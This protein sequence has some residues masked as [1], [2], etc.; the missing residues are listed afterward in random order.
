MVCHIT[1]ICLHSLNKLH[2]TELTLTRH[3]NNPVLVLKIGAV[4]LENYQELKSGTKQPIPSPNTKDTIEALRA[5]AMAGW[6]DYGRY[7]KLER[8]EEA[9]MNLKSASDIAPKDDSALPGISNNLGGCL[10]WRFERLGNVEDINESIERYELATSLTPEGDPRRA[11]NLSNMGN[12]FQCRFDWLGNLTDLNNAIKSKQ[13]AVDLTPDGH[14]EKPMYLNN[15][16]VSLAIRF[17]QLGELS[18]L[19]KAVA[20]NQAAVDLTPDNHPQKFRRLINLGNCFDTRFGRFGNLID[21]DSAITAKQAALRLVPDGHPEK[22]AFLNNLGNSL[23]D[24]FHR[25]G[26]LADLNN[27]IKFKQAAADVTPEDNPDKPRFLC[28]LGSSLETRFKQLGNIVDLNNAVTSNQVAVDLTPDNHPQKPH[29]LNSLGTSLETRFQR[30]GKLEDIHNAITTNQMA[31]DL[32]PDNHLHKPGRL[33]NLGISLLTRFKTLGNSADIDLSI[34]SY[35]TAIN[36]TPNPHP[37]RPSYLSNLGNAF[38][39]RHIHLQR[40]QDVEYAINHFSAAATSHIGPPIDRFKAAKEWATIASVMQHQSLLAAYECAV[41]VMPLVAWLGLSIVDRHQHLVEIGGITRDAAAAAISH[42]QFE[43]A[44][45]WLEQG[46]S[47][48]W[49]QILELRTPVDDLRDVQPDLAERLAQVS[50]LL[51]QGLEQ[52]NLSS[53]ESLS[54]EDYEKQYR[55]LTMERE[56]I[57]DQVRALPNFQNFLKSPEASQ[58]I[59]AAKNGPIVVLN[60][61]EGRC[62]ALALLP[63]LDEVVHIPL[64]DITSKRITELS[65][66]LSDMLYS[67]GVRLRAERAAMRLA[68]TD[69]EGDC[70]GILAELWNGVVKPVFDSLAFSVGPIHAF[71]SQKPIDHTMPSLI[72]TIFRIFGGVQPARSHSFLYTLLVSMTRTKSIPR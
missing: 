46:R 60:I 28:N 70:K 16:G 33:N 69:D 5:A 39:I 3:E 49:T 29:R 23:M 66:E 65:D 36:L 2:P 68:D 51:D 64:P 54:K 38:W 27:S 56:S 30:L 20:S 40:P 25:L 58:L 26:N 12:S 67:N 17:E 63:G 21:V 55:G 71:S 59:K 34:I 14:P 52:D 15:L 47:I 45:A 1:Q 31:V 50:R 72:L 44:L 35:E 24:R 10:R 32:T 62:D 43:R 18:D 7:G 6:E 22:P 41:S 19:D 37:D 11:A 8:L 42:Q 4:L 13:A 57:I 48:V 9:I 61:A 53:E